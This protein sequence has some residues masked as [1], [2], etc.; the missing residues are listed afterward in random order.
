M[1]Y[2]E[3]RVYFMDSIDIMHLLCWNRTNAPVDPTIESSVCIICFVEMKFWYVFNVRKVRVNL[4][5]ISGYL[6]RQDRYHWLH[7]KQRRVLCLLAFESL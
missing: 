2:I 4:E 1:A 3:A 7:L 6:Q 5:K